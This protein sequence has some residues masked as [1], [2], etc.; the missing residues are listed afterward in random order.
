MQAEPL[1]DHIANCLK[2]SINALFKCSDNSSPLLQDVAYSMRNEYLS[3]AGKGLAAAMTDFRDIDHFIDQTRLSGSPQEIYSNQ[4]YLIKILGAGFSTFIDEVEFGSPILRQV[5]HAWRMAE[6]PLWP[7]PLAIQHPALPCCWSVM[8]DENLKQLNHE[9]EKQ[10]TQI[11]SEDTHPVPHINPRP[12]QSFEMHCGTM[13]WS[14]EAPK[15]DQGIPAC[16]L[17]FMR[18]GVLK[19]S[20]KACAI[21]GITIPKYQIETLVGHSVEVEL[22]DSPAVR[23]GAVSCDIRLNLSPSIVRISSRPCMEP[24]ESRTH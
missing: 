2:A 8:I 24:F 14:V 23:E 4:D 6:V 10:I 22:V 12:K 1:K 11:N 15:N 16:G 9:L 5:E 3:L 18:G 20:A 17:P 13:F 7:T 21:L 19:Q